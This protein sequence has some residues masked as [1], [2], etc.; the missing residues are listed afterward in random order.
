MRDGVLDDPGLVSRRER[1]WREALTDERYERNRVAVA[2]DDEGVVG[3]AMSGPTL[4]EG[5]REEVQLHVLYLL[6]DFHGSGLADELL[7]AVIELTD[8]ASLWVADPNPRA[9]AFYLKHGFTPDG[10]Y[11]I[12]DGVREVRMTR[13]P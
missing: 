7:N 4:D 3:I 8:D 5:G 2:V 11:K 13:R 1:F 10:T 6:A 12:D 9:Q